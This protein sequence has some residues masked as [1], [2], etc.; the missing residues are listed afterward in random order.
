MMQRDQNHLVD[1]AHPSLVI[2][3]PRRGHKYHNGPVVVLCDYLG[4]SL[5]CS[6]L[7]HRYR[8]VN[9]RESRLP[10]SNPLAHSIHSGIV[11]LGITTKE[12]DS[13]I[14][15]PEF[16]LDWAS[17]MTAPTYGSLPGFH[18]AANHNVPETRG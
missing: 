11:D 14:F 7:K 9:D 5:L 18:V 17:V 3:V 1:N 15:V 4:C 16:Y 12:C 8:L 10:C 13:S 6:S 2:L